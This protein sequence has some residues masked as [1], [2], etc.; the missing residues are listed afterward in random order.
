MR[1][2]TGGTELGWSQTRW[3]SAAW[4]TGF[5]TGYGWPEEAGRRCPKKMHVWLGAMSGQCRNW[6]WNTHPHGGGR[7]RWTNLR[8]SVCLGA[9]E[10]A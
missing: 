9:L 4:L 6:H 8:S 5:A 10:R 2:A 7:Y 1:R 3:H